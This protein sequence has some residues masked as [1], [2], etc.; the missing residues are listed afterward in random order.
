MT[1]CKSCGA[2][3]I[4][5]RSSKSGA[6]V[7]LD[8]RPVTGQEDERVRPWTT[9]FSRETVAGNE[10]CTPGHYDA[11]YTQ[12]PVYVNHFATCPNA[13]EHRRRA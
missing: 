2:L 3:M 5:A 6:N 9:V 13:K 8:A 12:G 4:W 1:P 7:P 11:V 10:V